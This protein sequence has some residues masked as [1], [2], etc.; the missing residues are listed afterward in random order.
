[1]GREQGIDWRSRVAALGVHAYTAVG[2]LTAMLALQA[3]LAGEVRRAF[4]WLAIAVV[5]DSTDGTLARRVNVKNVVPWLDGA[6]MD[7][8]V[9]YLTY[10]FVPSVLIYEWGLL[11]EPGGWLIAACPLVASAYGFSRTDA[12]TADHFFTG[13]P[14]YWNVVALY[15]YAAGSPPWLNAAALLV[16][17]FLVFVPIRYLYPS[18]TPTLRGLTCTLGVIWGGMLG[19]IIWQLPHASPSL[20]LA[21]AFYPAYY[22]ALSLYL[23]A[24]RS[25]RPAAGMEA[26]AA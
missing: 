25:G 15:M 24:R 21:S 8:I 1:M 13:F 2:A 19:V 17:S 7:D 10:V 12:K 11:P 14:S 4:V 20:L 16:L 3:G 26:G 9:D 22:L 5:I 23:G 6:R 18:R